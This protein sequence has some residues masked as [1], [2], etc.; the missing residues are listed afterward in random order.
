MDSPLP[1]PSS[2]GKRRHAA[3]VVLLLLLSGA[4]VLVV[5]FGRSRDIEA[6][7]GPSAAR[8]TTPITIAQEQLRVAVDGLLAAVNPQDPSVRHFPEFVRTKLAWLNREHQAGHLQVLFF[9]DTV[10][11][12]VPADI[13]MASGRTGATATIFVSQTRLASDLLNAGQLSPPFGPQQ[14]NDFAIALVHE[15]LHLQN[16]QADPEDATTY[17]REELR[18]WREVNMHAVRPLR[19]LNEPMH[20]RFLDVDDALTL[21]RDRL[22]CPAIERLARLQW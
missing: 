17:A 7:L 13:V 11:P 1:V 5:A 9:P 15:V 6:P 3:T 19:S 2:G 22:P 4:A 12:S 8:G 21:C 16:A 14:R 18:V 20:Q 10:A